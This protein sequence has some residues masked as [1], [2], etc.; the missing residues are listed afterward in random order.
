[1]NIARPHF[2]EV[3]AEII[4]NQF[5]EN[6]NWWGKLYPIIKVGFDEDGKTYPYVVSLDDDITQVLPDNNS[7]GVAFFE[8]KGS[9]V[10]DP[11]MDRDFD[12]HN[13]SMV[14]WINVTRLVADKDNVF[15]DTNSAG[16]FIEDAIYR[17]KTAGGYDLS[18]NE[19]QS[20]ILSKYTLFDS[21]RQ[22]VGGRQFLFRIDFSFRSGGCHQKI[23]IK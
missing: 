9:I 5:I 7:H 3:A 4:S 18:V 1:M 11:E 15:N 8:A 6:E 21:K 16:E 12:E 13:M 14:F 22:S 10:S 2:N 20:T 17:I 19:D 23:E